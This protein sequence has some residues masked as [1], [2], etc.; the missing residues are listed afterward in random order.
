MINPHQVSGFK[1]VVKQFIILTEGGPLL[2]PK[3]ITDKKGNSDHTITYGYGYTF[4]R[5][6][7]NGK[8]SIYSN[9]YDDLATS[10]INIVIE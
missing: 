10:P 3:L 6:G 4:I 8:W 2:Q 1:E 5:K 7:T 9:L